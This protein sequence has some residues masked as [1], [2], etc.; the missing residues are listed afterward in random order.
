MSMDLTMLLSRTLPGPGGCR[1]WQ[2]CVQSNGYGRVSVAGK[3]RYAHRHIYQ[4]VNGPIPVGMDVCHKC[5]VRNCIEPTHLFSGTRLENMSDAVN[6]GRQSH[7]LRCPQ[8][9]VAP[10]KR[11][12][13]VARASAGERYALIA[14]DFGIC[15]QHAGQIA[16]SAGIRRN[17]SCAE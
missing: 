3:S 11:A 9:K 8:T 2:G 5:D 10:E 12:Q 7:G 1:L 17:K 14:A 13:I 6:K 15:K 4:L 16:I